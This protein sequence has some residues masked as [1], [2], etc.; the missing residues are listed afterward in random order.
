MSLSALKG[1]ECAKQAHMLFTSNVPLTK[2]NGTLFL[3][4][5]TGSCES[6]FSSV[7]G[8]MANTSCDCNIHHMM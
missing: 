3:V 2:K 8:S 5:L 4:V 1:T 7:S 6:E